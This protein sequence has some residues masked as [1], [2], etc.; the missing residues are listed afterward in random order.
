MSRPARHGPLERGCFAAWAEGLSPFPLSLGPV[1][2]GWL[3]LRFWR[4]TSLLYPFSP[5]CQRLL[6]DLG[7]Q[8]CQGFGAIEPRGADAQGQAAYAVVITNNRVTYEAR[9]CALKL[10][11]EMIADREWHELQDG[12]E[13]YESTVYKGL[14]RVGI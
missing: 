9:K 13:H 2:Q 3:S 6:V 8:N 1:S 14:H 4:F 10:G 11:V 5:D 12:F 7:S